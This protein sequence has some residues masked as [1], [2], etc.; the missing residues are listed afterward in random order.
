M[1]AG[2]GEPPVEEL[3]PPPPLQVKLL[4]EANIAQQQGMNDDRERSSAHGTPIVRELGSMVSW[5]L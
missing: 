3:G 4:S 5:L 1:A 2:R